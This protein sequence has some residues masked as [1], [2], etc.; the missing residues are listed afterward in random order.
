MGGSSGILDENWGQRQ[1]EGGEL[2]KALKNVEC[3]DSASYRSKSRLA[4]IVDDL[5]PCE[6]PNIIF[7]DNGLVISGACEYEEYASALRKCMAHEVVNDCFQFWVGDL[8]I[9]GEQMFGDKIYQILDDVARVYGARTLEN[10][11]R[12]CLCLP[13]DAR[14]P[15][16]R[17]SFSAQR[18]IAS[19][20]LSLDEKR[21]WLAD[22]A[23]N[24]WTSREV[25]ERISSKS[26]AELLA[27]VEDVEERELWI[28]VDRRINPT[29][30]K[31][32]TMIAKG[33]ESIVLPVFF[34]EWYEGVS[35]DDT[36]M[37][38]RLEQQLE[39]AWAAGRLNYERERQ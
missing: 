37:A 21:Q 12:T 11:R 6:T 28:T 14:M 26:K 30:R 2:V 17:L 8:V 9:Q 32:R 7:R 35:A 18:D 1:G 38:L 25:R 20:P 22:A 39:R 31:L 33:P 5:K 13:H 19:A 23:E 24:G 34:R 29:I 36:F 15:I 3:Y 10:M 4:L 27:E 16:T